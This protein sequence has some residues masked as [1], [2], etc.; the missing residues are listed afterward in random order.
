MNFIYEVPSTLKIF[1]EISPTLREEDSSHPIVWTV[2][3]HTACIYNLV[4]VEKKPDFAE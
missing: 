1:F 2:S 3:K 4:F